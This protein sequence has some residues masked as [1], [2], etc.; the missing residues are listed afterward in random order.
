MA[1]FHSL[2]YINPA[3]NARRTQFMATN[4]LLEDI[5]SY[6][7]GRWMMQ[8]RGYF[9]SRLEFRDVKHNSSQL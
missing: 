8:L 7:S 1:R 4:Y 2:H 5:S 6:N 3:I 9:L